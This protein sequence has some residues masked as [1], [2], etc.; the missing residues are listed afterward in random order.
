[1]VFGNTG[2]CPCP[3]KIMLIT[4]FDNW[5]RQAKRFAVDSMKSF[6]SESWLTICTS[7]RLH[8]KCWGFSLWWKEWTCPNLWSTKI[9]YCQVFLKLAFSC[10]NSTLLYTFLL[11]H[12]KCFGCKHYNY[13]FCYVSSCTIGAIF[14]P[15]CNFST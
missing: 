7:V 4:W 1:M 6:L 10:E 5:H 14:K 9:C 3:S 11:L 13:K 12:C 15:W 8:E 2:I